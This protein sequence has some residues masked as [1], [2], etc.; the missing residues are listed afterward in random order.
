MSCAS[1]TLSS[2]N[3]ACE[4]SFGGIKLVAIANQSDVSAITVDATTKEV[5]DIDMETSKK[6]VTYKFR[7]NTGSYTST[8]AVDTAIG[9]ASV[10]TE[11]TLQFSKAES[12]K[13]LA[14]QSAINAESVV[15]VQDMYD[16]WLLVGRSYPTGGATP[17]HGTED[18]VFV[19]N[20]VM[21]S[22][23]ANTDLSGFTMTL[24]S[25]SQEMPHFV[26]STFNV[27]TIIE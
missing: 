13:R 16:R 9:N 4:T 24:S 26:S 25:V 23:T 14:I 22:G 18:S 8:T 21:Q 1:V 10:T 27:N 7:R 19:T 11:I 2:I 20:A 3:G 5:T 15:L 17:V 12:T 6:F